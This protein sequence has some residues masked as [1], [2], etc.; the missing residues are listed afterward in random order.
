[1]SPEAWAAL[2][3]GSIIIPTV[4]W[5]VREVLK[6]RNDLVAIQTKVAEISKDCDR[7]QK[8]SGALQESITRVDRNVVRLC[9]NAG[10]EGEFR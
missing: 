10:I 4:G 5:L 3:V 1:M 2:I 6:L 9:Q 7:H 8:W